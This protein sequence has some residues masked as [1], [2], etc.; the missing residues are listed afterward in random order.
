MVIKLNRNKLFAALFLLAAAIAAI[1]VGIAFRE[2]KIS[3]KFPV[4]GKVIIIDPGHGGMDPGAYSKD[5]ILEK[6]INLN[7]AKFLKGYLQQSGAKVIMT[8]DKDISLHNDN[9][10]TVREKK[11]ADLLNRKNKVNSSGADLFISIHQN[12]FSESKYKGAQ[13]FYCKDNRQGQILAEIMQNEI[14]NNLDSENKR[15]P[16][17]IDQSKILFKDL[18]V[19]AV[20]V[21]CGF[22]SNSSEAK[23]LNNEDYQRKLAFSIY[24]SVSQ[25]FDKAAS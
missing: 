1:A 4:D 12:Y 14:R 23:L 8:R 5:G 6:D 7:I 24:L 13:V 21:E 20:L 22:L 2:E 3:A 10:K 17:Q 19:P 18:K 16:M 15:V 11:R 25:F 9:D